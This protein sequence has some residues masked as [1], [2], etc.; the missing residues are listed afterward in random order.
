MSASRRHR[1]RRCHSARLLLG[2]RRGMLA[3]STPKDTSKVPA[4]ARENHLSCR[5]ESGWCS[6]VTSI[7]GAWRH[8]GVRFLL[9]GVF[10]ACGT[11]ASSPAE[12]SSSGPPAS[13]AGAPSGARPSQK[14]QLW[15]SSPRPYKLAPGASPLDH[16]A[17]LSDAIC[18]CLRE[19]YFLAWGCLRCQVAS[20]CTSGVGAHQ[21]LLLK[22]FPVGRVIPG[23]QSRKPET[24]GHKRWADPHSWPSCLTAR[25]QW[26]ALLRLRR[27]L[28][29][30]MI[31]HDTS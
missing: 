8:A 20:A 26:R 7:H 10:N 31:H 22:Q 11:T 25:L 9:P 28:P 5:G 18:E 4:K 23:Q 24:E 13:G 3:P 1:R 30:P 2:E 15:G 12:P 29:T 14:W 19:L 27:W 21:W 6:D 17:K 16:S